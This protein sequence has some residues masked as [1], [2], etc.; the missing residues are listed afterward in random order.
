MIADGNLRLVYQILHKQ[1]SWLSIEQQRLRN[2][3]NPPAELEKLRAQMQHRIQTRMAALFPAEQCLA[4]EEPAPEGSEYY[5]RLYLVSETENF[6]RRSSKWTVAVT[7]HWQQRLHKTLIVEGG[8]TNYYWARRNGGCYSKFERLR[9]SPTP[10]LKQAIVSC[11]MPC[12]A[13]PTQLKGNRIFNSGSLFLNAADCASGLAD[14]FFAEGDSS[15]L[16][17]AAL[18]IEEAGGLV[19]DDKGNPLGSSSQGMIAANDQLLALLV[20]KQFARP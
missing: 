1:A 6:L 4:A 7:G 15:L 3:Q 12:G 2:K 5:W 19:C 18:L 11:D 13:L 10:D 17:L 8:R 20:K 16:M 9:A 14:I